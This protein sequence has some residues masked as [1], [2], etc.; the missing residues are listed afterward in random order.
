MNA[1]SHADQPDHFLLE[2]LPTNLCIRDL[3]YAIFRVANGLQTRKLE[4]RNGLFTH[5]A[6]NERNVVCVAQLYLPERDAWF[7]AR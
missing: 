5:A 1:N 2:L 6:E 3:C 4:T 7:A